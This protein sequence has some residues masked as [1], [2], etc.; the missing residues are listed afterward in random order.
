MATMRSAVV[1]GVMSPYP[2]CGEGRGCG[3]LSAC[4]MWVPVRA[5]HAIEMAETSLCSTPHRY[6]G[7]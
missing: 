3:G 2:T 5:I 1:T 4:T 6:A 7:A